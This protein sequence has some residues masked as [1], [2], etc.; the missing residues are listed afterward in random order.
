MSGNNA[1]KIVKE[2]K[3]PEI[4]NIYW[5][6]ESNKHRPL[7]K[8]YEGVETTLCVLTQSGHVG[9]TVNLKIEADA[10]KQFIGGQKELKYDNL[11]V[12]KDNIAY[13]KQFKVEYE[14][15]ENNEGN[16]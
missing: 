13:I 6:D 10:G 11:L 16:S 7:S 5:V 8:L 9:K 12:E 4:V 15:T 1:T 3:K 2:E 14:K